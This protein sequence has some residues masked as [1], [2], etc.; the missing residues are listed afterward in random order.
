MKTLRVISIYLLVLCTTFYVGIGVF[1][2]I[3][4][5]DQHF[6]TIEF[7]KYWKIVDGYM[8]KRM[9]IFMPIWLLVVILNLVVF[10]KTWRRS[11]IFWI[12]LSTLIILIIDISFTITHQIPI[13]KFFQSIDVNNLT[14]AQIKIVQQYREATDKNFDERKM[15]VLIVFILISLLPYLLPRLYKEQAKINKNE[16]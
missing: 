10:V 11:P 8:G 13:N 6:D 7:A 15:H 5:F 4:P 12:I 1:Q 3:C 14:E 2:L 9:S 16:S